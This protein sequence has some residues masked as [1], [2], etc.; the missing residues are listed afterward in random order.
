MEST[1]AQKIFLSF[2]N[3]YFQHLL[4]SVTRINPS[5]SSRQSIAELHS[6]L[7]TAA[8][9]TLPTVVKRGAAAHKHLTTPGTDFFYR[10]VPLTDGGREELIAMLAIDFAELPKS[11]ADAVSN[12]LQSLNEPLEPVRLLCFVLTK[13][14][15][16]GAFQ[17]TMMVGARSMTGSLVAIPSPVVWSVGN[18]IVGP[19]LQAADAEQEDERLNYLLYLVIDAGAALMRGAKEG[20]ST[21]IH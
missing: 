20:P 21:H 18:Q 19:N 17:R 14:Q 5:S 10:C 16:A 13:N 6:S 12:A 7:Q 11:Y 3:D 4:E 15:S 2:L 9:R 8:E 1:A